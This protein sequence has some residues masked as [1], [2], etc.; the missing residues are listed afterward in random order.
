MY[1]V[2]PV[3]WMLRNLERPSHHGSCFISSLKT[4][5]STTVPARLYTAAPVLS[6]LAVLV[7]DGLLMTP[8]SLYRT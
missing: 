8:A 5:V 3:W 4:D 1:R 2:D 7:D 6:T